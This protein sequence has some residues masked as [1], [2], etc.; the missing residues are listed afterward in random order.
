MSDKMSSGKSRVVT[1]LIGFLILFVVTFSLG[2]I[3]G[4]GI[5]ERS[6]KLS[7]SEEEAPSG[8]VYSEEPEFREFEEFQAIKEQPA[9]TAP[10]SIET[11]EEI[12]KEEPSNLEVKVEVIEEQP[13]KAPS[14]PVPPSKEI[15]EKPA[16]PKP[17]PTPEPKKEIKRA[18][19]EETPKTD[20]N[21]REG[22]VKLP[23]I[24]PDGDYTVQIGSFT[25]K[26]AADSVLKSM[27]RKGYPAFIN[28]MTDSSSKKWY[29]VRI[30]TFGSSG[31][32][33]EYGE[34]LKVLEPEVKIVFITQNN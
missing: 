1:L 19:I 14:A 22:R 5:S 3:V 18:A 15:A 25:D 20:Q 33:T 12:K 26:K 13:P 30:G 11:A 7:E 4:K 29:R 32:A 2:I 31:V 9:E 28:S 17:V 10:P 24:D 21:K 16:E 23:P 8:P 34:S 27:K 6:F